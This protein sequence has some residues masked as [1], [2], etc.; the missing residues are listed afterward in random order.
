[1]QLHNTSTVIFTVINDRTSIQYIEQ[2]IKNKQK[3]TPKAFP[4]PLEAPVIIT[5]SHKT[6]IL[7]LFYKLIP[8]VLV[9]IVRLLYQYY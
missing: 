2:E 1:M 5:L 7:Y 6:D 9:L 3:I 4:K 8:K